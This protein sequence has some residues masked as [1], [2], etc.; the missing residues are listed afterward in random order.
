MASIRLLAFNFRIVK[1][2]IGYIYI[3][4]ALTVIGNMIESGEETRI[5]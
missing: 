1:L 2:A 4:I 5:K 3:A